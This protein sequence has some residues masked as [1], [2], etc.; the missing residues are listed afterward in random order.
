MNIQKIKINDN[1]DVAIT[2]IPDMLDFSDSGCFGLR[3]LATNVRSD[4]RRSEIITTNLM[5]KELFGKNCSLRHHQSGAPYLETGNATDTPQISISHCRGM[6]AIAYSDKAVGVDV[7]QIE[8]RAARIRERVQNADELQHTGN[9]LVLNTILWT[10][11][12][13]LFK[14]IP[15]NGVDFT[16]DLHICLNGVTANNAENH[17]K[18][19]A[20]GREY[21]L[22]SLLVNDNVLTIAFE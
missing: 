16:K 1:I 22:I 18:A 14:L 7:E 4:N 9:S 13:A 19:T 5:V 21:N 11:K 3:H 20:Y 2:E 17:Y 10:A 12:E 8:E 15:E 6:V